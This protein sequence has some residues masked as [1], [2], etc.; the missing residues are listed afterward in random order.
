MR[1][2]FAQPVNL[3]LNEH[4]SWD[5]TQTKG[6]DLQYVSQDLHYVSQDKNDAIVKA[7]SANVYSDL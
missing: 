1:Y 2:I 6:A 3:F 7:E 4:I 5:A